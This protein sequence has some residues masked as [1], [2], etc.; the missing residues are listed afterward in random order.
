MDTSNVDFV[1]WTSLECVHEMAYHNK[2]LAMTIIPLVALGILAFVFFL[3]NSRILLKNSEIT[4]R[5]RFKRQLWKVVCFLMFLIYPGVSSVVL[6]YFV[7]KEVEGE[8]FLVA[9]FR[10]KCF[11]STW[12][13]YFAW[14][15]LMVIVYPLGIPA[16]LFS[17]LYK[18][19][20]RLSES[21]IRSQIGFLYAGFHRD[22]WYFEIVG[23][24]LAI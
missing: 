17:M 8:F 21:G 7:C 10:L 24:K 13:K 11:Q 14:S 5:K 20:H 18:Y 12:W 16:F 4:D 9:D 3:L 19:R 15:N 6:R 23:D 2:L 1:R 22:V